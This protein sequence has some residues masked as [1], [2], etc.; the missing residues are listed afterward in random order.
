MRCAWS[1]SER[2]GT[3]ALLL[4]A[5]VFMAHLHPT[6]AGQGEFKEKQARPAHPLTSTLTPH[7]HPHHTPPPPPTI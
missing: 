2:A 3:L 5:E 6:T 4:L 1:R 7:P